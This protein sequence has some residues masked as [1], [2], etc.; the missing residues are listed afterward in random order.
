M[1]TFLSA[2]LPLAL[3]ISRLSPLTM[4]AKLAVALFKVM[5]VLPSYVLLAVMPVTALMVALLISAAVLAVTPTV[6]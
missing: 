3:A 6:V 1:P 4:P 2:K 5:A